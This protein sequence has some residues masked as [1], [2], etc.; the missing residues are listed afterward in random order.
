[1]RAID[2]GSWILEAVQSIESHN[3]KVEGA[4]FQRYHQRPTSGSEIDYYIL[5]P[6]YVVTTRFSHQHVH[7]KTRG[8]SKSEADC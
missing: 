5:A 6:M 1:M 8:I 3:G 7:S 2:S 4:N